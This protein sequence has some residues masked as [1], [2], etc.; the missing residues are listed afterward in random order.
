MCCDLLAN[1]A[2][3]EM[4]LL[5]NCP[6]SD[7]A[8]LTGLGAL[9]WLDLRKTRVTDFSPVQHVPDLLTGAM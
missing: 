5:G 9:N 7:A 1:L 3:L 2:A 4:L 6:I 8:R